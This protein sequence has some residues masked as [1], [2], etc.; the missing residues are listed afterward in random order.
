[1]KKSKSYFGNRFKS[2]VRGFRAKRS[3]KKE[4]A[5]SSAIATSEFEVLEPRVLLSGVGKAV[6]SK[7]W[8]DADGDKVVAKIVGKGAAM[9][10][11]VGDGK[12]LDAA[13]INIVGGDNGA[14][15]VVV[16]P[17]GKFTTPVQ[18]K[19]FFN[20]NQGFF[21]LDEITLQGGGARGGIG[22]LIQNQWYNLTPG[23]TNIGSITAETSF[24]GTL[25]APG[26]IASINLTAVVV[27]NIDLGNA[28][29]G[30][31]NLSTGQVAKVDSL[32]RSNGEYSPDFD[33]VDGLDGINF[34]DI[35]AGSI[36]QINLAGHVSGVNNFLGTI[37]LTQ[38]GLGSLTGTNSMFDGS[39]V[40]EGKNGFLGHMVLG[41]GW[42]DDVTIDASGDLTFLADD[43]EGVITVGG[44]LN[45]GF[46]SGFEGVIRVDGDVSGL[47]S[48]TTDAI[49][50]QDNFS[51]QLIAK[52]NIA[53][54]IFEDGGMDN[55]TI[56]GA[57]I[58][59][60]YL[61]QGTYYSNSSVV[62]TGDI[63]GV[64]LHNADLELGFNHLLVSAGGTLGTLDV[65]N[66]SLNGQVSANAIGSIAIH[67]GDLN[68][69]V[70]AKTGNIGSVMVDL[71]TVYGDIRALEG[72]IGNIDV[73]GGGIYG[74]S[75]IAD[76]GNIGTM[77]LNEIYGG[78]AIR[79]GA[80]I[81][82][83][84]NITAI[85]ATTVGATAIGDS[86]ITANG[87]IGPITAIAYGCDD[88]LDGAIDGLTLVAPTIGTVTA[89]SIGGVAIANSNFTALTGAIG[90]ISGTGR[91]G[92][93]LNVT[94]NAAT[95][96]GDISGTATVSG[97]GIG[98][99][100]FDAN[101]GNIGNI[102]GKT[103]SASGYDNGIAASYIAASGDIGNV[104]GTAFAGDGIGEAYDVYSAAYIGTTIASLNG[105]ILNVTGSSSQIAGYGDGIA[106]TEIIA[107]N[108]SI[109]N[110][111][112]T[113]AG[114]GDGIWN[115]GGEAL[116]GIGT[117][118]GTSVFG[119]GIH[120]HD[121][122]FL[123]SGPG[124]NITAIVGKT[125]TGT[126]IYHSEFIVA[127][128]TIGA[129][130]ATPTGI[131]G[132]AI[133]D[134]VFTAASL[135]N[136]EVTVTN[137]LGGFAIDGSEFTALTG[138]IASVK[139]INNSTADGAF[140]IADS[141]FETR[142]G[143][144]GDVTVETHGDYSDGI[145]DNSYFNSAGSI[146]DVDVTTFGSYSDGVANSRFDANTTIGDVTIATSGAYSHGIFNSHFWSNLDCVED[147]L[148]IG[149]VDISVG[150]LGSKG[151]WSLYNTNPDWNGPTFLAEEIGT[152]YVEVTNCEGSDAI[153]AD[154]GGA[155]NYT[156]VFDIEND[157]AGLIVFNLSE[158]AAA[159][160]LDNVKVDVNGD[161]FLVDITTFG[162][163]AM[164][165]SD[166][167]PVNIGS[168]TLTAETTAIDN[169]N[170]AMDYS[171]RITATGTIGPVEATGDVA[172]L[173]ETN[174]Y[175]P[176]NT[177][178]TIGTVEIDGDFSGTLRAGT[179]IGAIVIT[180]NATGSISA[181][182]EANGSVASVTAGTVNGLSVFAGSVGNNTAGTVGNIIVT[183]DD[184]DFFQALN[185]DA[186][187]NG[188]TGGTIGSI[189][190]TS[191]TSDNAGFSV[192]VGGFARTLGA[193]TVDNAVT[194]KTADLIT[195][196]GTS[197]TTLGNISV[198]G[199]WY[200]S[201]LNLT[202]IGTVGVGGNIYGGYL[203]DTTA[204]LKVTS[205]NSGNVTIGGAGSGVVFY[206]DKAPTAYSGTF[207]ING[208]GY[209]NYA[210]APFNGTAVNGVTVNLV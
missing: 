178:T 128:G 67:G 179:N 6:T 64:V 37:R 139:V 111:T 88:T 107:L 10:V 166:I 161:I 205:G 24:D 81:F 163:W 60:L 27:P 68:A 170:G 43:F 16:S 140:G 201:S 136:I 187:Y 96:I 110:V 192:V 65:T 154:Y 162:G 2:A 131:G 158:D 45:V 172:G 108:G 92:G 173:I 138:D 3:A 59:T 134:S 206:I 109:G 54:L 7:S 41:N 97:H 62:A 142:V 89:T 36:D 184:P 20:P 167:D 133:D 49:I 143:N 39:I 190:A 32:M 189:T 106:E 18:T 202:L 34:Y 123:V 160:G 51:G 73:L 33:W 210:A 86:C 155:Y 38:G 188:T 83:G 203:G 171:S 104:T 191:I 14:L 182:G 159:D 9:Q 75:I 74:G 29:V 150:G 113:A 56:R 103:S 180:G 42:G 117:I 151:I 145:T 82:A 181:G 55:G 44:N 141:L 130:T 53:D 116:T 58:G 50:V 194:A 112:G 35:T 80:T 193:I 168:V 175:G 149:N 122:N 91:N 15:S 199:D 101:G 40:L 28:V 135:G 177:A 71:G 99:G 30:N 125:S 164:R 5:A 1:M 147:V 85:N 207:S 95:D 165:N 105:N 61:D 77:N 78:L 90:S 152:V 98:F 46:R 48:S 79:E 100:I 183:G 4:L 174:S 156:T 17:V 144:I 26:R 8:V 121:T 22:Q 204:G 186:Y 208:T 21:S 196:G 93:L 52:G 118:T 137:L 87:V 127:G 129:I 120:T 185:V 126:A 148:G 94:A 12:Y 11:D 102:T 70:I 176:P 66:G 13:N 76:K 69:Q 23:Y 84:G 57:K 153:Y 195:T 119:H 169:G 31:I 124:A 19:A 132:N 197:L 115:S 47:R 157:M 198:D 114:F 72:N 63:G 200:L 209:S 25:A 146:G